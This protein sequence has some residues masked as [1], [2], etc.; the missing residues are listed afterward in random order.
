MVLRK[1]S[2]PTNPC[3]RRAMLLFVIFFKPLR[4]LSSRKVWL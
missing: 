2:W 4:W 1:V 3:Q